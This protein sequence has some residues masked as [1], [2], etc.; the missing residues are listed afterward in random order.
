MKRYLFFCL[1]AGFSSL[2]TLG[3]VNFIYLAEVYGRS[4]DGLGNF[5]L[6]NLT[7]QTRSGQVVISVRE[8]LSKTQVLTVYS[9]AFNLL[10][11]TSYFPAGVYAY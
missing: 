11:G 10:P 9:P 3:Q 7:G 8:N 4:V 1:L 6:Q 5:Q 2:S